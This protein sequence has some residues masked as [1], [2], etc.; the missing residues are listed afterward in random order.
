MKEKTIKELL[1]KYY[2]P[3]VKKTV[4]EMK[5]NAKRLEKQLEKDLDNIKLAI[6]CA[7]NSF[8][9]NIKCDFLE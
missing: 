1:D 3:G 2:T 9:T 5:K 7:I 6:R 8:C 4:A